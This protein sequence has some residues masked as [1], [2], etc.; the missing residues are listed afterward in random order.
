MSKVS[1]LFGETA[2][3]TAPIRTV[4]RTTVT[5]TRP[6]N[7]GVT[8]LGVHLS[9]TGRERESHV[10]WVGL[11]VGLSRA[12]L[13]SKHRQYGE[14]CDHNHN[15]LEW[16]HR[17]FRSVWRICLFSSEWSDCK[18]WVTYWDSVHNLYLDSHRVFIMF[19]RQQLNLARNYYQTFKQ[20]SKMNEFKNNNLSLIRHKVIKSIHCF[21]YNIKI[22]KES[23]LVQ[24]YAINYNL[25][26][27]IANIFIGKHLTRI[28][29]SLSLS[30][31]QLAPIWI[32]RAQWAA[33]AKL[34]D[35]WLQY[36]GLIFQYF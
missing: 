23:Y 27:L 6:G 32:P 4:T 35:H 22:T 18:N 20:F 21:Q 26:S 28:C 10:V 30:C 14:D 8:A 3:L 29:C 5:D 36:N 16:T 34:Q 13:R 15:R 17:W 19:T 7:A 31:Q 2:A 33:I 24:Y 9:H 12:Y 11:E 1:V 25:Q